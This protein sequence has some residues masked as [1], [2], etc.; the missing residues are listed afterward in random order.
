MQ[1]RYIA[2]ADLGS[3]KIALSVAKVTGEDIQIIYYKEAPSDGVRYSCVFNPTRAANAL[4]DAV[5][6]AE[7]ELKIKILQIVVGL[8][9]YKV[10]Q[11][12][13]S[14]TLRRSNPE[15][16]IS[17][18]E[19]DSLKSI[20]LDQYPLEDPS[21]E[22]IYGAVAQSFSVEDLIHA[23]EED[24][25]GTTSESIDGNFKVFVGAKK[26]V[27]NIDVLLNS[28][29]IAP[30]RKY[31]LPHAVA[32][33]VLSAE[34]KENGV[35]LVE[36]GG[37]V[38]SLTIYQGGLLRYYGSIPFGGK[39]ITYDIK[40]EC[41]FS[42]SLAENI[43]FAYGACMPENLLSLKDKVIRIYDDETGSY[44]QLPVKKLSEII[45]YRAKEIIQAVLYLIQASGYAERLRNGIVLTGGGAN[46]ANLSTLLKNMSG[47]NVRQGYPRRYF[48]ASGCPG[49][50]ETSAVASVGMILAASR[51]PYLN[52][53]EEAASEE[54]TVANT[55]TIEEPEEIKEVESYEGTILDPGVVEEV[56]RE[57]KKEKVKK[58]KESRKS[59]IFG[60]FTWGQKVTGII[61][62]AIDGES[63]FG[64]LFDSIGDS[65]N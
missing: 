43:K 8:P 60:Q 40:Y 30:A 37:G 59:S 1:E 17:K 34:E 9:R 39:N 15:S 19:I 3:S 45:T 46:L 29:N 6:Q 54:D 7:E 56:P 58:T 42:E 47:Y 27:D 12:I 36:I 63:K 62:K 4:K 5:H 21:K 20:A 41:G 23:S 48:S 26:A 49:I 18:E 65:D 51:D 11:E 61:N 28:I 44:D 38:T 33:A 32:G 55:V 16:C 13:S 50:G 35:A 24:V 14:G 53:I 25:V 10:R 22:V 57:K 52:C 64:D 2:T 31:F